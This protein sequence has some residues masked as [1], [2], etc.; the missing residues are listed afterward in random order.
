MYAVFRD[1]RIGLLAVK[2]DARRE[3]KK[4]SY[5]SLNKKYLEF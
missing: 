3:T 1:L 4:V 2:T 5:L